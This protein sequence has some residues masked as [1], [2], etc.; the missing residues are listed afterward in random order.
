MK[1]FRI[2]ATS[3]V[4]AASRDGVG[5]VNMERRFFQNSTRV[6]VRGNVSGW[7]EKKKDLR[8]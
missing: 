5:D 2:L 8:L 3:F 4:S 1:P 7:R 6:G